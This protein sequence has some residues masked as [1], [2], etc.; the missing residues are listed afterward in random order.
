[1]SEPVTVESMIFENVLNNEEYFRT[2]MPHLD[3]NYFDGRIEKTL[4]KFIKAFA[5][6]H[7]K[8]PTQRILALMAKEYPNFSQDEYSAAKEFIDG[9]KGRE[10]NTNWL[11]ERTEKFC[12]DKAIFNAIMESI[13]IMDGNNEAL[14]KDAIPGLLQ[15]ALGISFDKSIGH[16]YFADADDRYD[17]YHKK[18]DRIPFRLNY[19][20][21][22]TKGGLPR[23]TLNC[24]LAGVNVGKS[25]FLCDYASSAL[26]QG[27]NVLYITLEMAEEKIAERIDCNLL[28]ATLDELGKFKR[29][30][31]VSGVKGLESKTHG[32]LIIKEYPTGGAHVG[33]F[34]ALLEELKMKQ[35]FLPDVIIIDY[36]NICA[37]L[38]YKSSNFNSYFAIKSIAEEL[39]GLMVEYNCVGLTATQLTRT[40]YSDSDFDM[41][42]TSESFG[43]PATLDFLFGIIRTEELDN[44]HQLMVKQLKS[45]YNDMN[46]YKKFLLGINISKFKLYDV[47]E[48]AQK[49]VVDAGKTDADIPLFDRSAK[50]RDFSG[51]SFD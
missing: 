25:L 10:E 38:K 30:D 46:Y 32:R 20:N 2:V 6:K 39:R 14:N 23:K 24:A 49:E 16:D 33:H 7:N 18:E 8:A 42:D 11:I 5:E 4:L 27:Y 1:M 17:F 41:T 26:S 45:R 12:R 37:S 51:I 9:L 28:D 43:L 48:S 36:I 3:E 19:F 29:E 44:M 31:F 34:R 35:N 15:D 40:G 13:Q 47:E 22:I 50:G 21:K